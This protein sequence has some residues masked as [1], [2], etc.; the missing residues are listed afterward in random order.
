MNVGQMSK[1]FNKRDFGFPQRVT[2]TH[3]YS[4]VE[5]N[6]VLVEGNDAEFSRETKVP[7][8]PL[9]QRRGA[10]PCRTS[11]FFFFFTSSLSKTVNSLRWTRGVGPCRTSVFF[12]FFCLFFLLHLPLRRTPL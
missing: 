6:I 5:G 9:R 3:L 7:R 12:C 10:G 11:F 8:L 1:P 4:S 2:G